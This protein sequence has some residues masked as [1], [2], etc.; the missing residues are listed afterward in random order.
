MLACNSHKN[1]AQHRCTLRTVERNVQDA[2]LD[3]LGVHGTENPATSSSLESV[4]WDRR[5]K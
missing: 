3:T 5:G 1:P 2:P 4:N